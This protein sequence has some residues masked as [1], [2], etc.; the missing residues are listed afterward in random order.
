MNPQ[1]T[2]ASVSLLPFLGVIR[3]S[4]EDA[5]EFL[6]GQL[7]HDTRLLDG[8]RTQLSACCT[9]QGR[10][11]ALLRLKRT[12]E[13]IFMLLP[14]DVLE[15][16]VQH[17]RR[18]VLRARVK[19]EHAP[20]LL[21]GSV[22]AGPAPEA[23]LSFDYSPGRRVLAAG[24][25]SWRAEGIGETSGDA[26]GA[27]D[28]WTARD[29]AEG[30]PQ[31]YASASQSYTPQMLNLDLLD[32]ISFGK[33]CYTG[34]EIVVRTQHLG[35][36]KRRTLRYRCEGLPPAP[37]TGLMRAEQKLGEVLVSAP[38]A[39]ACEFLAVTSLEAR[40]MPLRLEDGR[41]VAEMG[42]PY[43]LEGGDGG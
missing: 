21:C 43:G 15:S 22:L 8:G 42:L 33:G 26:S 4:G 23:A 2:P 24:D 12:D 3:V 34:Q 14:A 30:I 9:P 6:Q 7:T 17:L 19:L 18:Y 20:E 41:M 40:G 29:I 13:G 38:V 27:R 1:P 25:E 10:V 16:L 28:A 35:R 32:G 37:G 31:V 36:I 39:D 5:A 11:I